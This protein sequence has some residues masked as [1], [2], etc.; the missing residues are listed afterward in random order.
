VAWCIN[1]GT[2]EGKLW[3]DGVKCERCN[4]RLPDVRTEPDEQPTL[5]AT[6]ASAPIRVPDF[7]PTRAWMS[8]TAAYREALRKRRAALQAQAEQVEAELASVTSM[9]RLLRAIDKRLAP[10]DAILPT[11][12][13]ASSR[14]RATAL[15]MLARAH[16][17]M[18]A[19]STQPATDADGADAPTPHA[20]TRAGRWARDWDSCRRCE[21]TDSPHMGHGF[22]RRCFHKRDREYAETTRIAAA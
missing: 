20:S 16:S 18:G 9:L 19:D 3:T 4:A 2:V 7:P 22:C 12:S 13:P 14:S 21:K 15:A 11:R 10:A 1:C 17:P 8:A 6:H 5:E